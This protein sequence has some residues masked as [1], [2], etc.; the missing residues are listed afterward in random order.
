MLAVVTGDATY[1]EYSGI[2]EPPAKRRKLDASS[3]SGTIEE[4]CAEEAGI[5][6]GLAGK[7]EADVATFDKRGSSHGGTLDGHGLVAPK[8]SG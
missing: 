5:H 4:G 8:E 7:R 2:V 6:E 1:W 3:S